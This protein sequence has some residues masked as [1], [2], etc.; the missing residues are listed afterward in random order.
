MTKERRL[1]RG[2]EALL[3]RIPA[4]GDPTQHAPAT[5]PFPDLAAG[6]SAGA[7]DAA[8]DASHAATEHDLPATLASAEPAPSPRIDTRLIDSNPSQ[9]RAEFD[10]S[11]MQSLCESISR[12]M[13]CSSRWSCGGR[14]IAT[15]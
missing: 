9:P 10:E 2:L 8:A 3:S 11:E 12:P 15:S 1:G 13:G 5:V 4:Q 7:S 6:S 14:A